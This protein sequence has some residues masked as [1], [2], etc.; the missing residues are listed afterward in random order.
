MPDVVF[1]LSERDI[2]FYILLI[3]T[4]ELNKY[5]FAGNNLSPLSLFLLYLLDLHR[6]KFQT[7][8]TPKKKFSGNRPAEH[9]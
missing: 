3:F 9:Y 4:I 6:E 1:I 8:A 2:K 5:L 7:A